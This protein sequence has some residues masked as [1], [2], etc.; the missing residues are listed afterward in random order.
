MYKEIS[1]ADFLGPLLPAMADILSYFDPTGDVEPSLLNNGGNTSAIALQAVGGPCMW[2]RKWSSAVQCISQA[3]PPVGCSY[4]I[5]ALQ[6]ARTTNLHL[7][8]LRTSGAYQGGSMTYNDQPYSK[9][10]RGGT[11]WGVVMSRNAGFNDQVV[12][13]DFMYPSEDI[14]RRWD[15]GYRMTSITVTCD[16]TAHILSVPHR[17][18]GDET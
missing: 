13:L 18:P 12:E 11:Q 15:N 14:H 3:T 9:F 2:N 16:Q 6:I 5:C 1:G 8:T 10:L 17:K 4:T 7:K